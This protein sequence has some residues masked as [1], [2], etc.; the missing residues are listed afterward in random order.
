MQQFID[1]WSAT[2]L[3]SIT[4]AS[5]SLSVEPVKAALLTGLAGG[6]FYR[7]TLVEL[8]GSGAEVD[9]DV[10][11][12]TAV[13]GGV[14]TVARTG[15]A[16]SW[17]A[18]T[19]IEA[20]LTAAG[21]GELRDAGGVELGDAAPLA[22]GSASAGTSALA[23][24]ED[25][26]HPAPTPGDIGAATA[27]QGDKA[28]TAVQPAALTAALADKV[29]KEAGKGL[30][31][32]DFTSAEK[33][34]LAGLEGSHFKG[35]HASL[36]ALQAA[37]PTGAAGDYADVDAGAGVDVVRYLWDVTDAE[38]I[39][40]A[41][42]GG[43]MTAAE[44][45]TAYESNPD[46]NAF[47]DSEK[48]KLAGVAA[49]ATANADT[50]SLAEGATNKYFTEP[51][52][53]NTVLTGLSLLAGGAITAADSVLS[54]LGRLQKQISDAITA[55]GGK[56]DTLVSGTSLK[57]VNGSSLLG[58]GDISITAGAP[59]A[60]VVEY[61]GTA[62]TLALTDIN[63]IIDCTSGSAV[64][65]TIPPQSSVTWTADAEIH[66]RMSGTGQV[67]IAVGSGV[68]VP[69]L[70]APYLLQGRGA[71]VTLK[72]R[73][74]DVWALIGG[75]SGGQLGAFRNKIINGGMNVSQRGTSL[76]G[77]TGSTYLVD[78]WFYGVSSSATVT[79]SRQAD[80]PAG[81]EF[82]YSNR[83]TVTTTD[84]SFDVGDI[85]NIQ[86]RIEG[87]NVRDLVGKTFTLSFWVRSSKTGI[88]CV[89][90]TNGGVDR[91]YVA[92]YTINAANTW[93]FK[94]VTVAGGLTS[95]GTWDFTD[96]F[97][98]RVGFVLAAGSNFQTVAGAWQ[99]GNF[100]CTPNQV[101]VLDTVGNIFA[102]AGVQLEVG[103]VATPFE[104]RP[105]GA[106]LALCRRYARVQS[107]Y[108]PASTAQNLGTIDMR[109]VPTITGGGSGFT[110][111]GTTADQLIAYQTT[112]AVQAL[113]LSAEM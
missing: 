105:Y 38:W 106:E 51:R 93:E 63:T 20:R 86:Q 18:G 72:R 9:W 88:H 28:D 107:Y 25:H 96:G 81:G 104:H 39:A 97:G 23:S 67:S 24:R 42:S 33:T 80:A 95:A 68:T 21:M 2:L 78:R 13:A 48:T 83:V 4:E 19:L 82:Q 10:V 61:T 27:A 54:A 35:L 108:V 32:N 12:V 41:A 102:I 73:S 43:S 30:S 11:Q 91:T 85:A 100:F 8:D 75:P 29:D 110:S 59:L 6:A 65:I 40:Q 103:S 1:N 36:A 7:L 17:A 14:L 46:T 111:T 70:I 109:A 98:L 79:L 69:P 44:V 87:F 5:L 57:T 113:T 55:I 99:T 15:T 16:R 90:F 71:I 52:V 94:T 74:S 34:K 3:A 58:A 101:N 62:K 37:H 31:S 60:K 112:A 66:V 77:V 92:E 49:G 50:D 56:Q 64:T 22:L 84:T 26:Q 76:A 47:T 89:S 53:R 45:K